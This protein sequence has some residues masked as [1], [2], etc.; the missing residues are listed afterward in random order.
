MVHARFAR[1]GNLLGYIYWH[2]AFEH[3]AHV[4][5]YLHVPDGR[6]PE[7][8]RMVAQDAVVSELLC[9]ENLGG[10]DVDAR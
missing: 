1:R 6:H 10:V 3:H 7:S 5:A 8:A 2:A 4:V 9:G